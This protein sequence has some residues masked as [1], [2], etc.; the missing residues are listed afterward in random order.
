MTLNELS[1]KQ[2]LMLFDGHSMIFRAWYAIRNPMVL[3][4]TGEDIRAVR[5][6]TSSLLKIV[7]EFKPSHCAITFDTPEPTFRHNL[8]KEYKAH[9]SETPE[10][11][12]SQFD[13]VKQVAEAF[14]IP[15]Y[16][17]PGYEADDLLGTLSYIAAEK[18]LHTIIVTGDTD[19]L[20]LVSSEVSVL[21]NSGSGNQKM[22][23]DRMVQ[24][25]YLGLVPGQLPDLKALQGD[26]SDNI[27]G[28]PGIGEKTG[29][30]LLNQF[31][32]LDNLY[33]K[34]QEV[35]PARIKDLLIAHKDLA[36]HSKT[37]AKIVVD[38]PLQFD[39][40]QSQFGGFKREKVITLFNELEFAGLVSRIPQTTD[41]NSFISRNL[42]KPA[43]FQ[44]IENESQI[45]LMIASI[46]G[47]VPLVLDFVTDTQDPIKSEILGISLG[48][49]DGEPNYLSLLDTD[50]QSVS[51]EE[52]LAKLKVILE[53]EKIELVTHNANHFLTICS[54]LEIKCQNISFDTMIAASL[55]G[56]RG[57][58]LETLAFNRLGLELP[59]AKTVLS[60][61]TEASLAQESQ[62]DQI[63]AF[64]CRRVEAI[65]DLKE[66]LEA[67]LK[68]NNQWEL[69]Q[70]VEMGLVP[71]LVEIQ[72]TGVTIDIA[73]LN[74]L[75]ISA[76]EKLEIIEGQVY[77]LAGKNFNIASP[78]QLGAV[79]F[80][81]LNLPS[82]KR[83]KTGYSTDVKVL[84]PLRESYP[85]VDLVLQYRELA[86][87]QST[88]LDVLPALR[89]PETNRIHTSY[90]QVGTTTGRI[91]SSDPNLQ[92]IPVRTALGREVRKAFIP[93]DSSC[94][95]FVS[96]DYSQIE[97]R[98]LA[99]MSGDT[100]LRAA[101]MADEDVHS[102]TAATVYGVAIEDVS[103][104]MRRIAKI[105]NF[106]VIYG[107]SPYGISQQTNLSVEQGAEFV[108]IY[109]GRYPEIKSY[110]ENTKITAKDSGY[111]E[112][113]LGRRRYIPE[114]N[115]GDFQAR[116]A[117]ERMA[118]NM[119]I[120]GSAADILKIATIRIYEKLSALRMKS[121]MVLHVHDELIFEARNEEIE[122]LIREVTKLMSS[123]LPLAVPLK[124]DFKVGSTWQDMESVDLP[125]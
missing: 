50:L 97:L 99:H 89:N 123:A 40:G 91:S 48:L 68:L 6:F 64:S 20:Q 116:Q 110:I 21:L 45:D 51:R 85:I 94:W 82:G 59:M 122:L 112:T 60:S 42:E 32:S 79:L 47:A 83:T 114:I 28:V 96:A 29:I 13:R 49:L 54:R 17:L 117:A 111:V 95:K 101:F 41:E 113:I 115:S 63:A 103:K 53:N 72:L 31:S 104:D 124:V 84:E 121:R 43:S 93:E 38:I 78:S 10:G 66:S 22:Y 19:T 87:L 37:L 86:K 76:S 74:R 119:P 73:L 25:R 90:N 58:A 5:G 107:L 62:I 69:F 125:S 118:V 100:N 14:D 75:S 109:F 52:R 44:V 57:V 92:N 3:R 1:N 102:A 26:T 80:G 4:K 106:G 35:E 46:D 39:I 36:Y 88:Y 65:G 15:L 71:V 9:R 7:S 55:G 67:E 30:K 108:G 23:D 77:A 34:V 33:A 27:P 61:K 105:M 70:D 81:E 24:D 2:T 8:Y 18:G 120:Q 12:L 16:E 56:S 11:L 98:V